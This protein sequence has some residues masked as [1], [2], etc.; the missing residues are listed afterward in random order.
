MLGRLIGADVGATGA[1]VGS[2]G[3]GVGTTGTGAGVGA[4]GADVGA[5]GAGVPS[6]TCAESQDL[7]RRFDKEPFPTTHASIGPSGA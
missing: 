1:K 3:A 6:W 5:T 2:T 4:T 7:A